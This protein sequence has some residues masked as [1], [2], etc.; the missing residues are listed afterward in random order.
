MESKIV[1]AIGLKDSPIAILW[2]DEEPKEGV[3][4][5]E[6]KTGCVGPMLLAASKGRIAYFDR[7]TIGCPGGKG[8][9]GLGF[10]ANSKD[11]PGGIEY[12]LSNGNKELYKTEEGRKLAEAMPELAEGEGYYKN[13]EVVK[14]IM[15]SLPMQQVPTKYV[16]FKPLE[17][18]TE[19]ETPKV[20]VFLASADQLSALLVLAN[21][22]GE[23]NQNVIAPMGSGCSSIGII[24]YAEEESETPRAVLGLFDI[25][26]RKHFD[27]NIL[28]FAIPYQLFKKMEGNVEGSFL[29]KKDWL[30]IL[31]RN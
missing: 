20:V 9:L 14:K 13:P 25:S 31:A 22:E 6:G 27:K 19:E 26:I 2:T 15:Q 5:Q 8:G 11:F 1:R 3:Q 7:K 29:E 21:Y 12:F 24:P 30:E 16:V 28:S 10:D 23:H 18:V 4:F 17:K